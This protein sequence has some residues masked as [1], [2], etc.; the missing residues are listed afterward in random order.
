M[1]QSCEDER[2]RVDG[3]SEW[4]EPFEE[5]Q[6]EEGASDRVVRDG[7]GGMQVDVGVCGADYGRGGEE[8]G[9]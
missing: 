9:C 5:D 1:Q 8:G 2:L 7:R 4:R 3:A 6:C